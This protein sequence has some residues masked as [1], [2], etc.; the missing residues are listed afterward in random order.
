MLHTQLQL[1]Q[2]NRQINKKTD[3]ETV[4]K[5]DKQTIKQTQTGKSK[6]EIMFTFKPQI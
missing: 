3:Q 6:T 1:Y 5:T 2:I 4:N